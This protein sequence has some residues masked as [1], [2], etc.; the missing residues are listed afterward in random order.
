L[1]IIICQ[2]V[3]DRNVISSFSVLPAEGFQ[4]SVSNEGNN[5]N[6]VN[7]DVAIHIDESGDACCTGL[8]VMA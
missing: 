2:F 4:S 1:L 5:I 8:S 6:G 7:S 3:L